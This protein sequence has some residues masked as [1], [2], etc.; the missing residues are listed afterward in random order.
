MCRPASMILTKNDV[1]YDTQSNSHEDI[2][3]QLGLT[4]KT[5]TPDFVRVEIYPTDGA[6]KKDVK[7]WVYRV[8]Q[9][10][11]PDWY[12]AEYYEIRVRD[13]LTEWKQYHCCVQEAGKLAMLEGG[14]NVVQ[15]V[16]DR[17]TQTARNNSTQTAG[18]RSTQT[19]GDNSAQTAGDNSAQKAGDRSIQIAGY[20]TTQKAG[21][22][23]T[24]KA[25]FNSTQKAGYAATQKAGHESTQ[26]A[27]DRSTQT[28]GDE[29]TQ[30][31]GHASTQTAESKST[32]KAGYNSTQKAGDMSTQ[33]AGINTIQI[34][35]YYN[36]IGVLN[37]KTRIITKNEA[38]KPYK[39]YD[40]NWHEVKKL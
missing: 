26:T 32:Q 25:E 9:D 15:I 10:Y 22:R 38:D 39:F 7:N 29:S 27:G 14:F 30:K 2:I 11:L 23:S 28:A 18:N 36:S 37:V 33:T 3:K 21:D 17:S 16:G 40:G 19:S 1:Y 12:C 34:I 5:C 8:D 6:Y 20:A 13:A 31:A 4:D 24:Q 35:R